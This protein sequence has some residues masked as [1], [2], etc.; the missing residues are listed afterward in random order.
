MTHD[1]FFDLHNGLG[2][3]LLD[4]LGMMVLCHFTGKKL[5]VPWRYDYPGFAWGK[6]IYDERLI[7]IKGVQFENSS[8]G[9]TVVQHILQGIHVCPY[10][11][12][13]IL[14]SK[15]IDIDFETV[16]NMFVALAKNIQPS[17]IL[18]SEIDPRIS[19][20]YGIHLRKTDKIGS[21]QGHHIAFQNDQSE[22]QKITNL[23]IN[24]I[25]Q[26]IK[27]EDSPS[28]FVCSEDAAWREEF[29][30]FIRHLAQIEK[31][32]VL[33]IDNKTNSRYVGF[34]DLYD[35]FSLS[36]SKKIYQ[37]VKHSGYSVLAAMIGQIELVNYVE[38]I[39]DARYFSINLWK[40]CVYVNGKK[41]IDA[42]IQKDI[43]EH[44]GWAP[45]NFP[46]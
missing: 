9:K 46:N 3:R 39:E 29:K 10:N 35:F 1:I 42:S 38:Q 31:K 30:G 27:Q 14:Q 19:N 15:H 18:I 2:D 23:L 24:D 41:N 26:I 40:P 28:F 8:E 11:V 13:R 16:A 5:F 22:F 25:L 6:G 20:A 33:I 43:V 37:G 45:V 4:M 12:F 32:E 7:D 21:I 34:D 17:S 36:R 44:W